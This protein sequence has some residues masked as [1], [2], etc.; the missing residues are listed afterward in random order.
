MIYDKVIT[1]LET[2][3]NY[4]FV[5]KE[6]LLQALVHKSYLSDKNNKERIFSN[7][8]RLEFLGDAVLELVVTEYLYKNFDDKEGLLTSLRASL[9][10]Y[11]INGEVGNSLGLDE[12]MLISHG[13]KSELGKARLSIVADAV[14]AIIGAIYLDGGYENSRNFILK[15]IIPKLPEII[16][17]KSYKDPKTSLQELVQKMIHMTPKYK[18]LKSDGKDHN[19]TFDIA[20]LINGVLIATGVGKSKQEAQTIAA[21]NAI[22]LIESKKIQ[23]Q[24]ITKSYEL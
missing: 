7:N 8:E 6:L 3:I 24:E 19:K 23:L 11:K 15:F 21:Q 2:K 22:D 14:E 4:T 5:N 18:L 17:N 13:E 10:N 9:V 12:D 16:K 20:V 1:E